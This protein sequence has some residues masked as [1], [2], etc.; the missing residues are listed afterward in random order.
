LKKNIGKAP[1]PV[2]RP[3]K[4]LPTNP[5]KIGYLSKT[6]IILVSSLK[7]Q[8][9]QFDYC[10]NLSSFHTLPL[11]WYPKVSQYPST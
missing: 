1:N 8:R 10:L 11:S 9:T 3:A 5:P 2:A 6:S 7:H 4:K